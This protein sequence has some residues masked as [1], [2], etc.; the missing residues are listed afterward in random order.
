MKVSNTG[1]G[2]LG[3]SG[4]KGNSISSIRLLGGSSLIAMGGNGVDCSSVGKVL[5]GNEGGGPGRNS[6]TSR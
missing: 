3:S 6:G 2:G 5:V 4:R 1:F